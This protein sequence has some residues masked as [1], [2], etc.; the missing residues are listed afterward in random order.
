M[1]CAHVESL[2]S[3]LMWSWRNQN[4][5]RVF[6]T[7][8]Q[9]FARYS[10]NFAFNARCIWYSSHAKICGVGCPLPSLFSLFWVCGYAHMQLRSFYPLSTF[11]G[12]HV[13]K[14]T[15]LCLHK[16][17]IRVPE[18]RSLGMRL[19]GNILYCRIWFCLSI[20]HS[21]S[22][23]QKVSQ[24]ATNAHSVYSKLVVLNNCKVCNNI[25]L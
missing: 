7:E 23:S 25:D 6:R 9:H 1:K 15:S 10:T 14:S 19:V 22:F 11:D 2:V 3:F 8:R 16:F 12:A 21:V 17:N 4:R 13:R 20:T 24:G 18:Q 5:T